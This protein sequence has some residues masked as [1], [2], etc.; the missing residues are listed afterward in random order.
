[1]SS[2]R[3]SLSWDRG[4]AAFEY[5]TSS[6]NHR[7]VVGEWVV[8]EAS[9]APAYLGDSTRINPED[10][11][12]AALS[13]CHMLTFLAVAAKKKLVLDVYTD[14]AEGFLE[15]GT[16]GRIWVTRVILRPKVV[17]AGAAPDA[18]VLAELHHEAHRG[19]FIANSVKTEVTVEA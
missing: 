5:K 16:D 13:S 15:K 9:S 11:L 10:M 14:E 3:A 1:M 7:V 18:A 2:H 19:C 6:R 4:G 17:F 8:L 12:V